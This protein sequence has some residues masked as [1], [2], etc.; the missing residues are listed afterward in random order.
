VMGGGDR[1]VVRLFNS[2]ADCDWNA[3]RWM[4]HAGGAMKKKI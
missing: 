2:H 3:A 1:P 4:R